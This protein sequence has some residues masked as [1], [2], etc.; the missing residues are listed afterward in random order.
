MRER[1]EGGG[2]GEMKCGREQGMRENEREEGEGEEKGGCGRKEEVRE[3]E[4][5]GKG[6]V[7]LFYKLRRIG[8]P[9]VMH[10][11]TW[12]MAHTVPLD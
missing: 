2:N 6:V 4:G 5:K 12:N 3:N 10:A 1:K 9:P 7:V 8:D 11:N